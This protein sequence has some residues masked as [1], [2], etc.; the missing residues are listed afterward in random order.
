MA[1]YK[2]KE[3]V[4]FDLPEGLYF[5]KEKGDE[6]NESEIIIIDGIEC[7]GEAIDN[8]KFTVNMVTLEGGSDSLPG[9]KT[10]LDCFI[11]ER[12]FSQQMR[13]HGDPDFEL[14]NTVIPATM[15][16]V[17][18][19]MAMGGAIIPVSDTR[20]LT[21]FSQIDMQAEEDD[22]GHRRMCQSLYMVLNSLIING[23]RLSLNRISVPAIEKALLP[24]D[25][26]DSDLPDITPGIN[27]TF[28]STGETLSFSE[29]SEGY[30]IDISTPGFMPSE[31]DPD[32]ALHPH[33]D[34]IDNNGFIFSLLGASVN[35]TGTEYEFY[36]L[37]RVIE[38]AEDGDFTFSDV[39]IEILKDCLEANPSGYDLDETAR[40]MAG[41]FHVSERVFDNRNDREAELNE[42][43]MRRAYMIHALRSFAWTLAEYCGKNDIA[44]EDVPLSIVNRIVDYVETRNWLNYE[45][46]SYCAGLCSVSDIHVYYLPD[47]VPYAER[48]MLLTT[49]D[50]VKGRDESYSDRQIR[51]IIT[52]AASLESLRADLEYI[53]PAI[54]KIY[55]D[56]AKTRD[57]NTPLEGAAS[58]ILYSWIAFSQAAALPFFTEDGPSICIHFQPTTDAEFKAR[59]KNGSEK[60]T[61][62]ETGAKQKTADENGRTQVPKGVRVPLSDCSISAL[63][64]LKRY[65]G[66]EKNIILPSGIKSIGERAFYAKDVESVVIPEGVE[67]IEEYAFNRLSRLTHVVLPK[68][69][70]SIEAGAFYETGLTSITIPE[71]CEE[72]GDYAFQRCFDLKS[73]TLP[74]SVDE[75]GGYVFAETG[76][77]DIVIPEGLEEI[78]ACAFNECFDL[79]SVTL[80]GSIKIIGDCAFSQTGLRSVDIPEGCEII[81][82]ECFASCEDLKTIHVPSTVKEIGSEAFDTE[83]PDTVVYTPEGSEAESFAIENGINVN[84]SEEMTPRVQSS[85]KPDR[86][87]QSVLVSK[88]DCYI[89]KS[90]KF[91]KYNGN[92][93]E[94]LLPEGISTIGKEAFYKSKIVYV[95][96][97]EGTKTIEGY[98][99]EFCH[100]LKRV[101]LPDSIRE[102]GDHAF[103]DS[104]LESIMIPERCRIVGGSAFL[105]CNRLK[106]AVMPKGC[107]IIEK[108]TF[109]GCIRL[110]DVAIP[111]EC[112]EIGEFAFYNCRKLKSIALPGSIKKIGKYAF[113]HSGLESIVIPGECEEIGGECFKGCSDMKDIYVSESVTGIGKGAFDTGNEETVIHAVRGSFADKYAKENGLIVEYE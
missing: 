21:L 57:M 1:R 62:K 91:G 50:D 88:E 113:K 2:Y 10:F 90:G 60:K 51:L 7:G 103:R 32:A 4:T 85:A 59:Y 3:N 76:L 53:Y 45:E 40:E 108:N 68:T 18:I 95:I 39:Q 33:Y 106:E 31:A 37:D 84:H 79:Q 25:V 105:E 58:D 69:L 29:T 96:I 15:L 9:G 42:G 20:L 14:V 70:K 24:G 22:F 110:A 77:T 89:T 67:R 49:E 71:G 35:T 47:S 11:D 12:E 81:G 8:Y 55:D 43:Y 26:S 83:C 98:A 92:E 111:E 52:Q 44:P 41:L 80:P 16:G 23:K 28:N 36:P 13:V 46:D 27:I 101:D 99:F 56:L 6:G 97:P 75:M 86:T 64:T 61:A 94:I 19:K 74:K 5:S 72:I 104:S 66:D 34:S 100:K 48:S 73:V 38:R 17:T 78:G 112:V 102:I 93:K 30:G 54:R 87:F 65:E 109:S 82:E 107:K 63:D